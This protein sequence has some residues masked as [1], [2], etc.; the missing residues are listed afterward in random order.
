MHLLLH[1]LCDEA[2]LSLN[3]TGKVTMDLTRLPSVVQNDHMRLK[4]AHEMVF[5]QLTEDWRDATI[6]PRHL[7]ERLQ[8]ECPLDIK[9]AVFQQGN[10]ASAKALLTLHDGSRVETVLMRHADQRNTVCVSSQVGCAAGC[11]FCVTGVLGFTRNLAPMEIVEQVLLFARWLRRQGSRV[12]NVVFMGMGEPMWNFESV[13]EAI[14]DLNDPRGLGIGARRISVSTVGIGQG[15]VRLA[16][17]PS[18]VNLAVS[19]NV[20]N[21]AIRSSIMPVN[22][23]Y[24]IASI[25]DAV[26]HYV[27][28][29]QR[30][31]MLEYVMLRDVNDSE[32][33]AAQLATL[34]NR[35]PRRLAF[36]N[37]IRHNP[38]GR[39][40]PADSR[41]IQRFRRILESANVSVTQRYR[42]AHGVGGGC[43]QLGLAA[44]PGIPECSG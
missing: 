34:V 16:A 3:Q 4:Q 36:V 44:A 23:A 8:E 43:G 13:V 40:R 11:T 1:R 14:K 30:R 6:L 28:R 9:A 41:T 37:L 12:T 7:R 26:A 19:L 5:R 15:I 39:Y 24:P 2:K 31:V 27:R 42:F 32:S 35:V 18:Q 20:P 22:T 10:G 25:M 38:T 29:T 21:D 17:L 33:C